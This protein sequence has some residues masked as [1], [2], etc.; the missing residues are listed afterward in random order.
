MFGGYCEDVF[1]FCASLPAGLTLLCFFFGDVLPS[2]AAFAGAITGTA[3]DAMA[4]MAIINSRMADLFMQLLPWR[5]DLSR[6]DSVTP[7]RGE[8]SLILPST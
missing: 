1:G 2:G 8:H 4:N 6:L 7:H 3:V 5:K